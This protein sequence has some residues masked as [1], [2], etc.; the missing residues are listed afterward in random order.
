M[1]NQKWIMLAVVLVLIGGTATAL[2][3]L[4]THQQ[5]G[6]PGIIGVSIPGQVKMNIDLPE[7]VLDFTSTNIPEPELV[8]GYLPKDSSYAERI[9]T[10]PDGFQAE[11]AMVL[12][13]ADRTSIHNAEYCLGGQGFT[14]K[15]KSVVNIPVNGTP[16]YSLPV[17]RW[18][19]SGEFSLPD[20]RK[21]KQQGV[22]I[23]WY[24]ADGE[25]TPDHF[26]IMKR[27]AVNLLTTGVLQRWAYV[28]YYAPC[29]AGQQ[30]AT[31]ERMKELIAASVPEFQLPP[32]SL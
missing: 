32:A 21:A 19:V 30:D 27:M 20:G 17:A 25:A 7:R 23:F 31:F 14:D 6:R 10:A 1:K 15:H 2:A 12:M 18:D 8:V 22:Y 11:A 4:K 26:Q 24:V 29:A 16:S 13:G 28:L 9:Y 5:L 3:W